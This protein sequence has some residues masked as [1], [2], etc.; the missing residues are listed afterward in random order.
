MSTHETTTGRVASSD[1]PARAVAVQASLRAAAGALL[2]G[3]LV[4]LAGVSRPVVGD[5]ADAAQDEA[6]RIALAQAQA[7]QFKLGFVL[8]G[9]GFIIIGLAVGM[10][11]R[12]VARLQTGQGATVAR[13]AGMVAAI[14]GFGPGLV[15]I[16]LPLVDL[17]RAAQESGWVSTVFALG[18]V[19]LTLGFIIT[20]ILNWRGPAPRWA[21]IVF[22]LLGLAGTVIFP[23]FFMFG[24]IFFGLVGVI[25]FR[26]GWTPKAA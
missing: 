12:A 6:T 17:E 1:A 24:A 2:L 20:G 18:S 9:V 11:D 16:V 25:R 7:G 19:A 15:R 8:M 14:G 13:V 5:W 23:A 26:R 3:G 22:A 4:F 10:W 21:G